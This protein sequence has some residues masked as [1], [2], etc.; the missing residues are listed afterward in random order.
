MIDLRK[1]INVGSENCRDFA[2]SLN[3]DF[4][5]RHRPQQLVHRLKGHA[6]GAIRGTWA[7]WPPS[8]VA[9]P[10]GGRSIY[11]PLSAGIRHI[12]AGLICV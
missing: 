12:P 7:G 6:S 11:D 9:D 8:Q 3:D 4:V 2:P 10:L 5:K 1:F